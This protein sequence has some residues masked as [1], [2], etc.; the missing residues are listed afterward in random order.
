MEKCDIR[1]FFRSVKPFI[2]FNYFLKKCNIQNSHFTL[3]MNK[4]IDYAISIEKL[5]MLYYMVVDEMASK[6]NE[7]K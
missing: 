2:K 1:Y 6:L 4:N 3:F 7:N 5:D